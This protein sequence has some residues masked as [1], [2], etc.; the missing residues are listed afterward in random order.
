MD[1]R[2]TPSARDCH[3][4][5]Y[6]LDAAEAVGVELHRGYAAASLDQVALLASKV[7]PRVGVSR[8]VTLIPAKPKRPRA[9]DGY[10]DEIAHVQEA[11]TAIGVTPQ[12]PEL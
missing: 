12:R 6:S 10:I 4:V 8:Q 5:S 3:E 1:R 11:S 2:H 7:D 9:F